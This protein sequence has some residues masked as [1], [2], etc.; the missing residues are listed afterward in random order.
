MI[1]RKPCSSLNTCP[2]Y[3]QFF[4][5]WTFKQSVKVEAASEQA[6]QLSHSRL[7]NSR[8]F[9]RF[10]WETETPESHVFGYWRRAELR[11]KRCIKARIDCRLY[12]CLT[13]YL[14]VREA[15]TRGRINRRAQISAVTIC[16]LTCWNFLW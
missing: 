13:L 9:L 8:T 12:Y 15:S 6:S 14:R 7:Q 3:F 10:F 4:K 16:V 5:T 2:V 11:R 1:N